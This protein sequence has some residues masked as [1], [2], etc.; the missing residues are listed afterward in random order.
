MKDDVFIRG[1]T[2]MTK[3]EVR[4]VALD[5]LQ[6]KGAK[7]FLDVGAGTGSVSIQAA[8]RYPNLAV[9][10]LER[11]EEAL[12]LIQ[13]NKSKFALGNIEIISAYAPIMLSHSYDAIFIGG[14]GGKLAEI[15]EWSHN[16]LLPDGRLVL[17]F[18][19]LENLQEAL[20]LLDD[21]KWSEIETVMLQASK[22]MKLGNGS[23]FKPQNPTY[24]ISCCKKREEY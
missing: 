13:L 7:R 18:I 14:S 15:I 2:P 17:N 12:E 16:L 8:A 20:N 23:F 9:T 22:L 19:L 3:E 11:N 21:Q 6:L 24:I 4:A 1:K 10:A 5:K